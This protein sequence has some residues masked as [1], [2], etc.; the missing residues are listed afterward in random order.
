V[1]PAR[2]LV[3]GKLMPLRPAAG[4][5][6]TAP[7]PATAAP[8]NRCRRLIRFSGSRSAIGTGEDRFG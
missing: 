8:D 4:P 3:V 5:T 1:T 7:A 6:T 2:R